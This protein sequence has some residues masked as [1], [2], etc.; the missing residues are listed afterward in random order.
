MNTTFVTL[1]ALLLLKFA[2]TSN[3]NE[4]LEEVREAVDSINCEVQRFISIFEDY[5]IQQN[6]PRK[7]LKRSK[8]DHGSEGKKEYARTHSSIES[9]LNREGLELNVDDHG[10]FD[11]VPKNGVESSNKAKDEPRKSEDSGAQAQKGHQSDTLKS[12]KKRR[13]SVHFERKSRSL[14]RSGAR[15][16][17]AKGSDSSSEEPIPIKSRYVEHTFTEQDTNQEPN[18]DEDDD[19]D[20][21]LDNEIAELTSNLSNTTIDDEAK[22]ARRKVRSSSEDRYNR[23]VHG[24]CCDSSDEETKQFEKDE[25]DILYNKFK[26]L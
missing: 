13:P 12:T 24:H 20:D 18:H 11:F 23:R 8:S 5:I 7:K 21:D 3:E 6:N 25:K 19:L 9:Q 2:C 17:R 10:R 14:T 1:G 16:K 4:D 26:S 15:R 22:C